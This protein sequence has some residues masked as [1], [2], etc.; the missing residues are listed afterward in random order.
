[1]TNRAIHQVHQFKATVSVDWKHLV[2]LFNTKFFLAKVMFLFSISM[3]H[4][5]PWEDLDAYM[6][7]FHEKALD[8]CDLLVEEVLAIY[9][10]KEEKE[11][12]STTCLFISFIMLKEA[13]RRANES[14]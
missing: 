10:H 14:V 3:E 2:S 8:C 11:F 5:Y 9:L 7:S 4:E 6:R 1:M 12:Y 13:A